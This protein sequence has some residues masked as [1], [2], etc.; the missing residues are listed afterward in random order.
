MLLKCT[1]NEEQTGGKS[2]ENGVHEEKEM[3]I[4]EEEEEQE[5]SRCNN[6]KSN[7]QEHNK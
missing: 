1:K 7:A 3:T 5:G 2:H 6:E 4:Q